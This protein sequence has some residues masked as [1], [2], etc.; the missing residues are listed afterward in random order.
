MA[1]PSAVE[2]TAALV[3]RGEEDRKALLK[4]QSRAGDLPC[5]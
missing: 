3:V 2:L 4:E 1:V 5:I